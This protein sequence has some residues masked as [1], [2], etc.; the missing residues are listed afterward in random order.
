MGNLRGLPVLLLLGTFSITDSYSLNSSGKFR[1][2]QNLVIMPLGDVQLVFQGGS[3]FVSC[4]SNAT[5]V[6]RVMW[7]GPEGQQITN[8]KG[9]IHVEDGQNGHK[10]VDLVF[11]NITRKDRGVYTCSAN[12]DGIEESQSFKLCVYKRLDFQDTLAVQFLEEGLSS[13]L[14]CDVDG[15]PTPRVSWRVRERKIANGDKY[16]VSSERPN[17]LIVHNVTLD[18]AGEYKCVALQLSEHI[19]DF[20][21]FIVN[22]KVHHKP[23]WLE[24]RMDQ[25]YSYMMGEVNLTCEA[26]AEPQ[27]N[28]T[29]IKEN[30][31]ITPSDTV[32]IFNDDHKSTLQLTVTGP[33]MFGD[34]LCKAEN[35]LGTLERAII[36]EKGAKPAV[37]TAKVTHADVNALH[38]SLSAKNHPKMPILAY[39][40]Q[41][42]IPGDDWKFAQAMEFKKGDS[43]IINSLTDDTLYVLRASAKNA[44]GYSDFSSEVMEKTKKVQAE[45]IH[46]GSSI[47]LGSS[48]A[49][50]LFSLAFSAILL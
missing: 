17:N 50:I 37:P 33:E 46:S 38:L 24:D 20:K 36:L 49:A 22:V 21:D 12:V 7:T 23:Q 11:D 19:S 29:W 30:K 1:S 26:V 48:S 27:A 44:A 25:A 2:A 47:A 8:Y 35:K 34:Y 40:V 15:D 4:Y 18:D 39:R 3:F 45:T 13:E 6:Q 16:E 14:H 5:N 41:Y 42:K 31:I 43:Y 10:G 28:F 32:Q 9:R